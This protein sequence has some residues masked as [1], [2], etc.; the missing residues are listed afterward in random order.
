MKPLSIRP[1]KRPARSR[2]LWLLP[3]AALALLPAYPSL[4]LAWFRFREPVFETPL[5]QRLP[6]EV[7]EDAYGSGLFGARRSGGRKHRG[8]DLAAP[9][10][11]PV[12]AAKSGTAWVG[13]KRNGMGRYV[14]IEHPD[15]WKTRYG[16][17]SEIAIRDR[18]RVRRGEP[19]GRVGKTGNA[20]YRR[21]RA[22]LHFEIWDPDGQPVDPTEVINPEIPLLLPGEKNAP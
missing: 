18:Q 10:G 22:H 12:L 21:M 3:T 20:R 19:I 4:S 13:K 11:T 1:R 9:E 8:I 2:I 16:H 15:G 14:V 5:A 17:L 6:L 7:R